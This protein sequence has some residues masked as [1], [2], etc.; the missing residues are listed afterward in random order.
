MT[1]L[2]SFGLETHVYSNVVVMPL[3]HVVK[4]SSTLTTRMWFSYAYMDLHDFA[5]NVSDMD[6]WIVSWSISSPP[7]IVEIIDVLIHLAY[8]NDYAKWFGNTTFFTH[9]L[10]TSCK[11]SILSTFCSYTSTTYFMSY[12]LPKRQVWKPNTSWPSSKR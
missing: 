2:W 9:D 3:S 4:C 11:I 10:P 12:A 6:M 7:W 8:G 5:S 1:G